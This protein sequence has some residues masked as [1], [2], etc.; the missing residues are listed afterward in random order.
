M[1]LGE[2]GSYKT[3]PHQQLGYINGSVT[4]NNDSESSLSWDSFYAFALHYHLRS[5]SLQVSTDREVIMGG[6]AYQ[7]VGT[8]SN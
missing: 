4:S 7:P 1:L 8:V 3:T 2:W 6:M 5:E